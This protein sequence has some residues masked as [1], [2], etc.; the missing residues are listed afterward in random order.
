MHQLAKECEEENPME[1][2]HPAA[3]FH[4]F[5]EFDASTPD[6]LAS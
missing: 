5:E 4:W 1:S 3:S 2:A 6:A